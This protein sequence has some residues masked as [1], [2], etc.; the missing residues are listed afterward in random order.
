MK[1]V[2]EGMTRVCIKIG[3]K[4]QETVKFPHF[5][6]VNEYFS[7]LF[8]STIFDKTCSCLVILSSGVRLVTTDPIL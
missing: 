6:L 7:Q 8:L 4:E 5:Y 1:S 3:Y 2:G